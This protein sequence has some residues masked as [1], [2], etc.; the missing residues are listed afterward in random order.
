MG[1]QIA[2]KCKKWSGCKTSWTGKTFQR[3]KNSTKARAHFYNT[4]ITSLLL[5]RKR[6]MKLPKAASSPSHLAPLFLEYREDWSL[7]NVLTRNKLRSFCQFESTHRSKSRFAVCRSQIQHSFLPSSVSK[8][9]PINSSRIRGSLPFETFPFTSLFARTF[10]AAVPI[11]LNAA[12]TKVKKR[13][14][15][16]F[17]AELKPK[18]Q[19]EVRKNQRRRNKNKHRQTNKQPRSD[20]NGSKEATHVLYSEGPSSDLFSRKTLVGQDKESQQIEIKKC[21]KIEQ[22]SEHK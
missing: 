10:G 8:T 3:W 19:K 22:T 14:N 20:T 12:V 1:A 7:L 2:D 17:R 5:A 16:S 4:H 9:L 21:W 13:E 6:R 11:V 18:Q 15:Y